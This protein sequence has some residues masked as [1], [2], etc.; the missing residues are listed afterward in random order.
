MRRQRESFTMRAVQVISILFVLV[1]ASVPAGADRCVIN[2][3][4]HGT[5]H[6]IP[7]PGGDCLQFVDDLGV[8]YEVTNPRGSWRDGMT[9][10]VLAE[11]VTDGI[12][13]QDIGDPIRICTFTADFSRNI[14]G[15]LLFVDFVE[16]PGYRIRTQNEDYRIV[17]CEDFGSD[18]C[19]A[20]N[21]GRKIQAQVFVDTGISIC[22]DSTTTVIDFRFLQ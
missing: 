18:L 17:N 20:S 15:T 11:W 6:V 5:F 2:Y 19:T 13:S 22:I 12:C 8:T 14:V 4:S 3:V 21:L 16:C 10:T 1:F 9:G 7:S